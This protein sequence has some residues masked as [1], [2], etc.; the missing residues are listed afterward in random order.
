MGPKARSGLQRVSMSSGSGTDQV[1]GNKA[2][3]VAVT[4]NSVGDPENDATLYSG[5]YEVFV[6]CHGDIGFM[7]INEPEATTGYQFAQ[8]ITLSLN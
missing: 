2:T 7:W 6:Y 5:Q 4:G 8:Y 1:Y 3:S